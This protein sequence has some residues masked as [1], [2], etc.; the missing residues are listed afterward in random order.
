[1]CRRSRSG[2]F[3]AVADAL[4]IARRPRGSSRS[5][6]ASRRA[7]PGQARSPDRGPSASVNRSTVSAP[8]P[9]I[10]RTPRSY[11]SGC[12]RRGRHRQAVRI[13]Q[14]GAILA[15]GASGALGTSHASQS[16]ARPR[17]A[18]LP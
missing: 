11:A 15:E 4:S 3:G 9:S 13:A 14:H 1:M 18:V 6:R 17:V 2:S 5:D 10:E 8:K 12:T 7:P 16:D